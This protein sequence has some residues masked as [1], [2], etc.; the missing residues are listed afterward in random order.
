M[1]FFQKHFKKQSIFFFF[2]QINKGKAVDTDTD[3]DGVDTS[4]DERKKRMAR[5]GTKKYPGGHDTDND[6]IDTSGDERKKRMGRNGLKKNPGGHDTDNDGV[7]TSGDERKKRMSK[8]MKPGMKKTGGHD[9][10]ND[11]VDTSG[12][13]ETELNIGFEYFSTFYHNI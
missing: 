3:H 12:K 6:G 4:G 8:A 2:Q 13:S 10:D 5:N 9:T 7:D 11:G 1:K